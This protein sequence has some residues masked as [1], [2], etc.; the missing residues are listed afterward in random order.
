M[1]GQ[2]NR[3]SSFHLRNIY[4]SSYNQITKQLFQNIGDYTWTISLFPYLLNDE[5]Q[6]GVKANV[7]QVPVN[8]VVFDTDKL[9]A[10]SVENGV[11]VVHSNARR[12]YGLAGLG[13][14]SGCYEW[15]VATGTSRVECGWKKLY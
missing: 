9:Q 2:T 8:D 3:N 7:D 4:P 5:N 14:K 6:S 1:N 13:I 10:C 12:G 11:T 15:K